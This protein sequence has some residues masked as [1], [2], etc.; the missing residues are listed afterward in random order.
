MVSPSIYI[1]PLR[2]PDQ[3]DDSLQRF[4]DKMQRPCGRRPVFQLWD[5]RVKRSAF[6]WVYA[7]PVSSFADESEAECRL[8]VALTP[9]TSTGAKGRR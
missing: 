6:D 2:Y 9:T 5:V 4:D 1:N 8:E 3:S 7:S